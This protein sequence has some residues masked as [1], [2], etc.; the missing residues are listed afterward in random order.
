MPSEE[1]YS[2]VGG[3]VGL[4]CMLTDTVDSELLDA[5]ADLRV[6]STMAVGVDN[7]DLDA[8]T[9][10]GIAVGHTP[11]VL[12]ETT[13]D[14][15]FG[16]LLAAAR[17]LGEG[18]DYVRAGEWKRW[19]PELLLGQ[20]VHSS[21]LGVIG[22]GRVGRALAR[23]AAGFG[24]RVLYAS[25]TRNPIAEAELGVLYRELDGLLAESDH[26]VISTPLTPQTHHLIGPAELDRMKPTAT[27]VNISRGGTVDPEA[28]LEALQAGRIAAAGLDV[29]E[30]E[31][32]P[33]DHP[34]VSL[35]NCFIVPHLGS[36]SRQTREAMATLAAENLLAGLR[37]ERL[38]ACAN[39][40]VYG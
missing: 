25:R 24:M 13:A 26:V 27:L 31:P 20:D 32:L 15:A 11:D 39:P 23:R 6:I 30:P 36:S 2:R 38:P 14:T 17:R 1:L 9:D 21:T 22:L 10:R 28:L 3:T 35:D 8:C 7:I 16:L 34:L 19:E 29:T 18:R 5:A 40:G 37:G 33:H 4:Y 12:T